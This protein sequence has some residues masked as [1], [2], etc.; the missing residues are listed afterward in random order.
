MYKNNLNRL[1][2]LGIVTAL[3]QAAHAW[4]EPKDYQR[5]MIDEPASLLD[6]MVYKNRIR[7]LDFVSDKILGEKASTNAYYP[8]GITFP[9]AG[10]KY[11]NFNWSTPHKDR[12]RPFVPPLE[13]RQ[14]S[15]EFNWGR[16]TFDIEQQ[17]QWSFY[18]S[19]LNED[20]NNHG[21]LKTTASN[22]A[23]MCAIQLIKMSHFYLES[24][25]HEGYTTKSLADSLEKDYSNIHRDT[26]FK[27]H[28]AVFGTHREKNFTYLECESDRESLNSNLKTNIEYAYIG[29]WHELDM[30]AARATQCYESDYKDCD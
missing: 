20:K 21:Q 10:Y 4:A 23:K 30:V 16:G 11:D 9:S 18:F 5:A 14:T 29:S 22:I 17:Y 19:G 7:L 1:L 12:W 26:R 24:H 6:L 27:I 8:K 3:L 28:I 25:S 2:A 13:K 15:L